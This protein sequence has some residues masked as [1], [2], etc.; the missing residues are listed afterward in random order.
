MTWAFPEFQQLPI[1]EQPLPAESTMPHRIGGDTSI[2]ARSQRRA[3]VGLAALLGTL[4]FLAD[5]SEPVGSAIGMAYVPVILLGL[6][7]RAGGT[8]PIWAAAIATTLVIVD[9]ALGWGPEMPDA[10]YANAPLILML[11]WVTAAVLVRFQGLERRSARQVKELADIKYALDQAAIVATTDVRGR[12]TYVNDKFCEISRYSRDELIGQDH[13]IINSGLHPKSFFEQ[14]W[15]TIASGRVWHGEI[16]NRAKDGTLYWVHTTIVPFVNSA[17]KPYQYTAIRNDITERKLA[18]ERLRHQ[19]ALARVGQLA[20]VVAHEVKNP[21]AGIRGVMQVMLGRDAAGDQDRPILQEVIARIDAL[22]DL[23]NDLLLFANPR[24]PR[25]QPTEL[26]PLLLDAARSMRRD[27]LGEHVAVDIQGHDV[28]LSADGELLKSAFLNLFLNAAHAMNGRGELH[29]TICADRDTAR[30]DIRD[31]GPGIP[32]EIGDRV[33]EPFFTT[34]ARG[35]GL[36]LAIVRRTADL[37]GGTV[38][39]ECPPGGGT[40]M[41]VRLP[42]TAPHVLNPGAEREAAVATD[43]SYATPLT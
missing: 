42:R 25:P 10:A 20:A 43:Q 28:A 5:I 16:R 9:T 14:L 34:K 2:R 18:E 6:W 11:F 32:A 21:L 39:F 37:H 29:V 41:S 15:Y 7:I 19:A 27:P 4:V 30:V 1:P 12:I 17:G 36:G 8:Y 26:R 33:F 22:S 23:I 24:A 35:G 3:I 31:E 40:L 13:R 38:T